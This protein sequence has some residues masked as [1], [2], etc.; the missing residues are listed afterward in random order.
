M[1]RAEKCTAFCRGQCGGAS[2]IGGHATKRQSRTLSRAQ[3]HS[4]HTGLPII[5]K[6][7]VSRESGSK[8][9][10]LI[11]QQSYPGHTCSGSLQVENNSA[12]SASPIKYI[13][14]IF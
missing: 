5:G 9:N 4:L 6:A 13:Q 1:S 11:D 10:H 14:L 3:G 8:E 2:S 12:L 7:H